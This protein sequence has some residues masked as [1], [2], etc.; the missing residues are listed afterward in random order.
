LQE[1]TGDL[2]RP[3]NQARG[4]VR[5]PVREN[6]S[7]PLRGHDDEVQ[8]PEQQAR[9]GSEHGVCALHP[10]DEHVEHIHFVQEGFPYG[11]EI[12]DF[13]MH[14]YNRG[15][16]VASNIANDRVELTRDEAF[17]YVKMEYLGAHRKDTLPAATAMGKRPKDLPTVLASGKYRNSFYVR[18]SKDGLAEQVFADSGCHQKL[19]DPYLDAIAAH[20]RFKQAL[21]KGSPVGGVAEVNLNRLAL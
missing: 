6:A 19:N 4:S 16:E 11:Y 1:I 20:L 15:V 7:E 9:D 5:H 14:V 3:P 17:E 21:D 10:I 12:L 2:G 18:V 13:Q 8:E